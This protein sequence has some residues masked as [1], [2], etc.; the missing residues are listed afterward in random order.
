VKPQSLRLSQEYTIVTADDTFTGVYKDWKKDSSKQGG[1][2]FYYLY[3]ESDQYRATV[4][5]SKTDDRIMVDVTRLDGS[6]EVLTTM[7]D[8]IEVRE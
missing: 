8:V 7:T 3:N 2:N 6:H 5:Y 1:Y 4:V